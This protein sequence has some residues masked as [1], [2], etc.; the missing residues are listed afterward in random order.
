MGRQRF[1]IRDFLA[2]HPLF[3]SLDGAALERLAAA[4]T[5][6]EAPRGAIVGHRGQPGS[7]M[8]VVV[9]GRR[10]VRIPDLGRLRAYAAD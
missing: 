5:E 9:Y 10:Q 6:C 7:E 2:N 1:P 8:H 4:T 3:R